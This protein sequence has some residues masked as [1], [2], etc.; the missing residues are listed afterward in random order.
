[1]PP[2]LLPTSR[3]RAITP[4]RNA[5][6]MLLLAAVAAACDSGR[7]SQRAAAGD[8]SAGAATGAVSASEA[9]LS[10]FAVSDTDLTSLT[11]PRGF[12]IRTFARD[13]KGP[14]F[15]AFGPDSALYVSVPSA[16][17]I[18]RL[19]DANGDG[20]ADT[21]TAVLTG[22]NRP[23]GVA[24]RGDTL[25][26]ANTDAVIATWNTNADPTL[27]GRRTIVSGL[28][29]GGRHWTKTIHF[30]PPG[31]GEDNYFYLAIGSS[32]NVCE[33][34]DPLRATISRWTLDGKPA[35]A[36]Q[37]MNPAAA[38]RL[39]RQDGRYADAVWA[40]GLRNAV[41]FGWEPGTGAMWATHNGSDMV[42]GTNVAVTDSTPE[43]EIV[44]VIR[45]GGFYGWPYCYE[46]G[47]VNPLQ[48]NA[49]A[50]LCAQQI[51]PALVDTAHVAPLGQVFYTA[52][53]FPAEYR[54]DEFI[55][56]HG[57]WNRT[58]PSGY[59]VVRVRVRNGQPASV[60]PFVSGW[61]TSTGPSGRPAG[62]AVGPDGSLYISD[63][64]SGRIYVV[65]WA[66][67]G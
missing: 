40:Y 31:K 43:E 17:T 44:N 28:P 21:S 22:L 66:G 26:V 33:E 35:G 3:W 45:E 47:T 65:R 18:M 58:K 64:A 62:L 49:T 60:E 13:L 36:R 9:P 10:G 27:E 7:Q 4:A 50:A 16:G 67:T 29:P 53:Q 1:M 5:A 54:G 51:A 15:M 30:P 59:R 20:R 25:W 23:H 32:C 63:D 34:R 6:A 55:A 19:V 48:K 41:D 14:R 52:S 56:E 39:V 57:S 61:L 37:L 8:T 12:V 42:G 46:K 24:W 11:L 2:F 38:Q